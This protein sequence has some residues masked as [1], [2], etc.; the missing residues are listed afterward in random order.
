MLC[1]NLAGVVLTAR[2]LVACHSADVDFRS[3]GLAPTNSG[4]FLPHGS[5]LM[6]SLWMNWMKPFNTKRV[7]RAKM[8]HFNL[9]YLVPITSP[10]AEH[11]LLESCWCCL[12]SK[13]T[14]GMP[15][16]RCGFPFVWVGTHKLRRIPSTRQPLD[17]F[18]LD[19]LDESVQ[20]EER[21]YRA[22][23]SHFNLFYLVPITSPFAEH[24]LLES[25]WC[26]LNSKITRG[27]PQCRCGFPFVLV[28][29]HKL[30][31][32]PSTWQKQSRSGAVFG[33]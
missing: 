33:L 25:C 9:F 11:A 16:C 2:S 10:F 26:C 27:M 32:I 31:R 6:Y 18:S 15:Q 1:L 17:V 14:C 4:E 21:V 29:T 28:G 3:F 24:A 5:H 19:E 22:K 23:M 13:I 8:S 30:R 7:Y 12:N 20:H